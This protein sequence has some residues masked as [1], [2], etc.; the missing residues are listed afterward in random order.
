MEVLRI[1][2]GPGLVQAPAN[3]GGNGRG[4]RGYHDPP[5][6][7]FEVLSGRGTLSLGPSLSS[8]D[9]RVDASV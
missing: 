5:S 2:A 8:V 7:I 3:C 9:A 6:S 4:R 1:Q